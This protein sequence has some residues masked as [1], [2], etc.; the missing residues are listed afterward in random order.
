MQVESVPVR[1]LDRRET[2]HTGPSELFRAAGG[3]LR[4]ETLGPDTLGRHPTTRSIA[5]SAAAQP[6]WDGF[7]HASEYDVAERQ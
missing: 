2:F 6:S 7:S 4:P 1:A 5:P 3:M